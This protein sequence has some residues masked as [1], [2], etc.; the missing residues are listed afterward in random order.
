MADIASDREKQLTETVELLSETL[1]LL[2]ETKLGNTTGTRELA[3]A[4]RECSSAPFS[5]PKRAALRE[6]LDLT[7]EHLGDGIA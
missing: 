6:A 7:R 5:I 3:A 1:A 2:V 4:L